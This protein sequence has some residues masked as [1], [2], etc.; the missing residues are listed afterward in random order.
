MTSSGA[1]AV[2]SVRRHPSIAGITAV[3]IAAWTVYGVAVDSDQAFPYLLWMVFASGLVLFVDGRVRFSTGVLVLLSLA[4]FLH[5][6]GGNVVIGDTILYEQIWLGFIR[7]DHLLHCLGLGAAGLA[8][9]ET[10]ARMLNAQGGIAAAV[11][12]FLGANTVGAFIEIGEYLASLIIPGVRVGG[13]AN[14]MQDLIANL[15][16]AILAAWWVTRSRH[17]VTRP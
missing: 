5:M 15:V 6:A 10:T 7:Y 3:Y 4:G 1:R 16:G 9:W 13:Y 17:E 12:V 2:S 14:N 11:V 8:V